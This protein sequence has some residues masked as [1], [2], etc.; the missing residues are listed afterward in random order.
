MK[1]I[2]VFFLVL[3]VLLACQSRKSKTETKNKPKQG[4][5][6]DS[7]PSYLN[8]QGEAISNNDNCRGEIRPL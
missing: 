3:A 2:A 6:L 4:N 1:N 8:R 7:H 5:W